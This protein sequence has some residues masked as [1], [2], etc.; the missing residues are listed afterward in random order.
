MEKGNEINAN[1]VPAQGDIALGTKAKRLAKQATGR[2]RI[3][4]ERKSAKATVLSLTITEQR[5][6]QRHRRELP[7]VVDEYTKALDTALPGKHTKLLYD[8]LKRTDAGIFGPTLH[9]NV[10]FKTDIYTE[11][12]P[13]KQTNAHVGRPKRL[14]ST[15]YLDVRNGI[16]SGS[17]Y[18]NRRKREEGASSS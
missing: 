2:E 13:R 16:N 4:Q 9:R 17:D 12:E 5:Q 10:P 3:G 7:K 6:R 8:G 14:S 11:L 1:W 15:T 18:T